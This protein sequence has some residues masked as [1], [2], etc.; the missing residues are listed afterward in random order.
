[1]KKKVKKNIYNVCENV[2][3]NSYVFGNGESDKKLCFSGLPEA[4]G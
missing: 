4:G 3:L 1:M 2:A